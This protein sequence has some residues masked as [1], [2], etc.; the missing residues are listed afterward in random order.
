MCFYL[1]ITD[2]NMYRRTYVLEDKKAKNIYKWLPT[3]T[4]HACQLF[5]L[6]NVYKIQMH[7]SIYEIILVH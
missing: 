1:M 3:E 2:C 7:F 4:G 5:N 6:F